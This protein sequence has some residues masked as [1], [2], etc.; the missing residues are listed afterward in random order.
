MSALILAAASRRGCMSADTAELFR[1]L[2]G[3]PLQEFFRSAESQSPMVRPGVGLEVVARLDLLT[4]VAALSNPM[5]RPPF[6]L[7]M[8]D[9]RPVPHSTVARSAR[10]GSV[11]VDDLT[12]LNAVLQQF[13]DGA[14]I[15]LREA[16]ESV[17]VARDLADALRSALPGADVVTHVF[18]TPP[19]ARG[20]GWHR[21]AGDVLAVQLSGSKSFELAPGL[22]RDGV[23]GRLLDDELPVD[24]AFVQSAVI[25][26]GDVLYVPSGT[27]HRAVAG[28]NEVSVHVAFNVMRRSWPEVLAA[29]V[30]SSNANVSTLASSN[31]T[32]LEA[33]DWL[34]GV[35]EVIDVTA[36]RPGPSN[37]HLSKDQILDRLRLDS[38]LNRSND[39]EGKE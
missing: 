16:G 13:E 9:G 14:T 8:K 24:P 32:A 28:Q 15:T 20:F 36:S 23:A 37:E 7:L 2:T 10:A 29:S 17:E 12:D 5:L 22:R 35:L 25:Q 18:I 27:P 30:A 38:S 11:D 39:P 34:R 6:I 19:N 21:D 1:N 33:M 31:P 26:Q 3:R 4:I